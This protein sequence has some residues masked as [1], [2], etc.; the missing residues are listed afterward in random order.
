MENYTAELF[1]FVDAGISGTEFNEIP[2]TFQN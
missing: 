1:I 2:R